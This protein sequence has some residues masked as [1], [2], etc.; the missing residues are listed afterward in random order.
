MLDSFP[1]TLTN[2]AYTSKVE[3]GNASG[4]TLQGSG[5]IN[6]LVNMDVD[7]LI[8]Y[9]VTANVRN[10]AQE[11]VDNVVEIAV[12]PGVRDPDISN[13]TAR[14]RDPIGIGIDLQATK[15]DGRREVMVGDVVTYVIVVT[16]HGPGP[17]PGARVTDFFPDTLDNVFYESTATSGVNGNTRLGTGDINDLLDLPE[18]GRATYTV[19]ATV[20]E[21][22]IETLANRV[23]VDAPP[24]RVELTP[25][26]NDEVDT[27]LVRREVAD[28]S[29]TKDNGVTQLVPGEQV[30][31]S[32]VVRNNGPANASQVNV[33]DQFPAA[34]DSVRY[35][36]RRI[37]TPSGNTPSGQGPIN[38]VLSLPLDSAVV[39]TVT[40]IVRPSARGILSNT[41][42]A[43]LPPIDPDLSNNSATDTDPLVPKADLRI[44]KSDGLA[45]IDPGQPL[46][47]T[48]AVQNAGPSDVEQVRIRDLFPPEL[49]DVAYSRNLQ[50]VITQGTGDIDERVDLAAGQSVTYTVQATVD[51]A[52]TASV[53]NTA[54]VQAPA[55]VLDPNLLNNSATDITTVSRRPVDLQLR[56]LSAE[57]VAVP[58]GKLHYTLVVSNIGQMDVTGA[59]V[60]DAFAPE[61]VEVIY[62]SEVIGTATGNSPAGTGAIQDTVDLAVGASIIYTIEARVAAGGRAACVTWPRS[63]CRD[64]STVHPAII[65]IW[66]SWHWCRTWTCP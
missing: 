19:T 39:Y 3:K 54:T 59:V 42:T 26:N 51:P 52:A 5:P 50:G 25:E 14:D 28:V 15:D 49:T 38:D 23:T 44:T 58:G 33:A 34:L 35:T 41:A 36:S 56:K 6:D 61:L 46:T 66:M 40:G 60:T 9:V 55:D 64:K 12:P 17:A 4:N 8:T 47:Y 13:N 62:T 7:S 43:T 20:S 48:I 21:R 53:R 22:A 57:T 32:I 31:Y 65:W 45:Q 1:D 27:N 16:N 37:G 30:T 10:D 18:A 11:A 29:V 63:I 2:I 24:D